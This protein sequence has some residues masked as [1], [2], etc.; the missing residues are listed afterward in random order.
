[1]YHGLSR[2]RLRVQFASVQRR[3][4]KRCIQFVG[5]QRRRARRFVLPNHQTNSDGIYARYPQARAC[6]FFLVFWGTYRNKS[7]MQPLPF[8]G[9]KRLRAAKKIID[10]IGSRLIAE[11]KSALLQEQAFGVK[12]N[13]DATGRD[14][15]TLLVRAN[16]RDTDA[17]N[18]SDVRARKGSLHA[19][20]TPP[21]NPCFFQRSVP[22]SSPVSGR[23]ALPC[24]GPFSA[25]AKI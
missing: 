22:S 23:R 4:I 10:R 24:H 21:H 6:L 14:L 5:R 8:A 2:F 15:L 9:L 18:D 1:M 7:T 25:F 20:Y 12:E 16:L 17:M 19:P 3:R 11:R 13:P